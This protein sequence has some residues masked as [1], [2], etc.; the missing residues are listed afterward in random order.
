MAFDLDIDVTGGGADGKLGLDYLFCGLSN[1]Q[2]VEHADGAFLDTTVNPNVLH[3]LK[4]LYASNFPNANRQFNPG[5]PAPV[6]FNM[7]LLDT[8]RYPAGQGGLG[9]D[10]AVMSRS[11]A[12]TLA[13]VQPAVG[14]RWTIQCVDSPSNPFPRTHPVN[15]NAILQGF[16][17]D[18]QFAGNFILWTEFN[19][20]RGSGGGSALRPADRVYSVVR[21]QTWSTRGEWTTNFTA[22][23]T[24]TRVSYAAANAGNTIN[25]VGRAQD[26]QVQVRPPATV[27]DPVLGNDA[28]ETIVV[29]GG[30]RGRRGGCSVATESTSGAAGLV[31]ALLAGA[32]LFRRRASRVR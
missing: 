9:G 5:D 32:V 2:W 28:R 1:N 30:G 26:H 7:P 15:A 17:I 31:L 22:P 20:T 19:K 29:G 4:S 27:S 21:V 3:T 13:A 11:A 25:P 24:V 12:H 6:L 8:G 14:Q 23:R 16:Q 18:W 10:A